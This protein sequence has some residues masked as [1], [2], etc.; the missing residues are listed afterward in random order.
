VI[1]LFYS[2]NLSAMIQSERGLIMNKK[3]LLV[4]VLSLWV[5]LVMPEIGYSASADDGFNPNANSSVRSIAVQANGM[6][7]VGGEFT[8]IGGQA[9]NYIARLNGDGTA[10]DTFNA[11]A[12]GQVNTIVLQADGKI[13]VGG[14]FSS[15]GG[16]PRNRIAR[17]NGDG[18]ADDT[19]N[20]D[21]NGKVN[22][23]VLQTERAIG[24]RSI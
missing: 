23:I 8:S 18:T 7:L 24:V 9:R 12:N 20:A 13:L 15:I 1:G 14:G 16:E 10:D 19:F 3:G 22:T 6:T 5:A 11:D 17:L 2:L 21:A 4:L